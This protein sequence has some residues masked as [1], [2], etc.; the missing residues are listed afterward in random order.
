MYSDVGSIKHGNTLQYMCVLVNKCNTWLPVLYTT[1]RMNGVN[2]YQ[3]LGEK[4]NELHAV[5]QFD[6]FMDTTIYIYILEIHSSGQK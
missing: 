2:A 4:I 1:P 6:P 5:S 3:I